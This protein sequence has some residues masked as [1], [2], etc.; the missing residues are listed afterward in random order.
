MLTSSGYGAISSIIPPKVYPTA[1]RENR[2]RT[3]RASQGAEQYDSVTL[4]HQA[5]GES[6]FHME[7]V[8]RL[9]QE[10][11]TTTTTGDIQA[12]RRQVS[13]GAY[14]PDPMAIARRILFLGEES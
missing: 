13:S 1:E 8:G 12:L 9:T 11:R 6:R 2:V 14:S 10:V 7:L 5:S 3:A 4:S